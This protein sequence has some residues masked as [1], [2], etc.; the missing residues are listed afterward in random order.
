[1]GLGAFYDGMQRGESYAFKQVTSEMRS[2]AWWRL[3]NEQVRPKRLA[4]SR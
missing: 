3:F 4:T 2:R 1:M